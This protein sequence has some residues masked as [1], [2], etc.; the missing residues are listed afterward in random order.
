MIDIGGGT[1]DIAIYFRNSIRFSAVFPFGGS[2][3]T[4]RLSGKIVSSLSVTEKLKISAGQATV[5]DIDPNE[6]IEF[7]DITGN[8]IKYK[9]TEFAENISKEMTAL[10]LKIYNLINRSISLE[11]LKAGIYLTG[12]AANLKGLDEL[13]FNET[14]LHCTICKPD[15]SKFQG[16]TSLLEKP[17][18]STTVGIFLYVLDNDIKKGFKGRVIGDKISFWMKSLKFIRSWFL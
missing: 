16:R 9:K 8:L 6:E 15:L 10:I 1:T 3:L 7:L 4:R 14:K 18:F 12:G 2:E 11:S 13:I 5:E 17:E